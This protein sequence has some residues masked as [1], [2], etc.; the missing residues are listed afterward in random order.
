MVYIEPDII[1][2]PSWNLVTALERGTLPERARTTL[3]ALGLDAGITEVLV[4]L[5]QVQ[6]LNIHEGFRD[7]TGEFYLV[8]S[9]MDGLADAPI[10]LTI[11]TFTGIKKGEFLGIDDPGLALY[12]NPVGQVPRFLDIRIQVVESDKKLQDAGKLLKQVSQ[13]QDFQDITTVLSSIAT[14]SLP[15]F[16]TVIDLAG[17]VIN[18]IGGMLEMNQDDQLCYYAATFTDKF[19]NLGLG[20][21]RH[22]K[23]NEVE[24]SYE[25]LAG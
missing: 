23:P 6:I 19:D 20:V 7:K 1:E 22:T 25:I 15:L 10:K 8:T 16:G 21:H 17:R 11:S 12:M 13:Q 5:K 3:M 2:R 24:F 14:T 4:R 9:V 18:V